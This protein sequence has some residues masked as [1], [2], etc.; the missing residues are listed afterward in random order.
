MKGCEVVV[1]CVALCLNDDEWTHQKIYCG[2]YV[3]KEEVQLKTEITR[4]IFPNL[5]WCHETNAVQTMS[6]NCF[7]IRL[8]FNQQEINCTNRRQQKYRDR[9][10]HKHHLL[11]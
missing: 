3:H 5:K 8:L 7:G 4:W 6:C 11:L 9:I 10:L 1:F 2:S